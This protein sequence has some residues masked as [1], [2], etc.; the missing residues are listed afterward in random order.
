MLFEKLYWDV[1]LT[2]LSDR[3][4]I[5]CCIACFLS[6]FSSHSGPLEDSSDPV[7]APALVTH[8]LHADATGTI[9]L[10]SLAGQHTLTQVVCECVCVHVYMQVSETSYIVP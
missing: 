5:T 7:T 6:F 4:I 10:P 3:S 2:Y 1:F 9:T 8:T